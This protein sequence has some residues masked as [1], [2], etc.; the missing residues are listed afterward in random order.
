MSGIPW[1]NPGDIRPEDFVACDDAADLRRQ[2]AALTAECEDHR[3]ARQMLASDLVALQEGREVRLELAEA[4]RRKMAELE[5]ERDAL[6]T[7][8]RGT[9]GLTAEVFA[10]RDQLAASAASVARLQ[11]ALRPFAAWANGMQRDY[12]GNGW[13]ADTHLSPGRLC[14]VG[15]T[16]ADCWRAARANE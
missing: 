8:L 5:A 11:E 12:E 16:F 3:N 13:T 4:V 9:H 7:A 15:P 1:T 2:V 6:A 10:L 14:T